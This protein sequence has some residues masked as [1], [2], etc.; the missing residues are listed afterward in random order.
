MWH[1]CVRL[2]LDHHFAGRDPKLKRLFNAY[3]KLARSAGKVMVSV[4]KT[5]IEF[6]AKARFAG[7]SR[8]NKDGLIG[9]FISLRNIEHPRLI[10]T[11]F[12]PPRYYVNY[13]RIRELTDLDS[14]VEKWLHE[15]YGYGVGEHLKTQSA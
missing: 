6:Q 3:L 8:I 11:E 4:S 1:S 12:I 13:F 5:R 7:V 15:A 10:K 14:T 9:S 2:T